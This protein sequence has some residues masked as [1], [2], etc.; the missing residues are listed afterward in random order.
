MIPGSISFIHASPFE[1]N[2]LTLITSAHL[3]IRIFKLLPPHQHISKESSS[4]FLDLLTLTIILLLF[5]LL[6]S[7][8]L[9][10]FSISIIIISIISFRSSIIRINI[11]ILLSLL[12]LLIHLSILNLILPPLIIFR[13]QI[14]ILLLRFLTGIFPHLNN[15]VSDFSVGH[16]GVVFFDVVDLS[17]LEEDVC[18]AGLLYSFVGLFHFGGGEEL[19]HVFYVFDAVGD[20]AL[21]GV[22]G[23]ICYLVLG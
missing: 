9:H 22:C 15:V 10:R 3:R 18:V 6:T 1:S 11:F 17:N 20:G 4:R 13:S 23:G 12:Q 14:L 5:L 19:F 21:L 7:S 16:L 8:S 2:L